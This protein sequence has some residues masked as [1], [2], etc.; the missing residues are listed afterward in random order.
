MTAR[1]AAA[2]ANRRRKAQIKA[3]AIEAIFEGGATAREVA[4][5]IGVSEGTVHRWCAA[6]KQRLADEGLPDPRA[7][8]T[9]RDPKPTRGADAQPSEDGERATSQAL[10][11]IIDG[12]D[13]LAQLQALYREQIESAAL[14]KR[15]GN[16]VAAQRMMKAATDLAPTIARLKKA[17]T[18][19]SELMKISRSEID[20]AM[21]GVRQRVAQ[22]ASRPL[23]CAHCSRELS[24]MQ[25][26]GAPEDRSD[27]DA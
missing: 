7:S 16:W 18:D 21:A 14:A 17:S 8:A 22:Y 25:G 23:L 13:D 3:A 1:R 9:P 12:G 4:H 27:P 6:E 15:D 20:Q 10:Q 11:A 24:V 5:E 19:E 2:E 26:M